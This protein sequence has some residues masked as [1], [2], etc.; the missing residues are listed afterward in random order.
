MWK[1]CLRACSD[2]LCSVQVTGARRARFG[3]LREFGLQ[4]RPLREPI[5]GAEPIR[6]G[7]YFCCHCLQVP[8]CPVK[9]MVTLAGAYAA[10]F[11]SG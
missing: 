6:T 10:R 3:P 1:P 8:A 4:I 11:V 5:G 9:G 2:G 7:S